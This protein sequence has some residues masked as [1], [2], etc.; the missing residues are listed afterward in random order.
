MLDP[1][2]GITSLSSSEYQIESSNKPYIIS[3]SQSYKLCWSSCMVGLKMWSGPIEPA[4]ELGYVLERNVSS[5]H[6]NMKSH[7][8]RAEGASCR[9]TILPL[10]AY[11]ITMSTIFCCASI[12]PFRPRTLDHEAKFNNFMVWARFP[13][14]AQYDST[15]VV[16][17]APFAVQLVKQVNFG[18]LE[19]K[20]YLIPV[21]G[22]D[23]TFT[24]I[25][26]D[27]LIQAN[28]QKLNS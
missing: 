11:L 26:E 18:P 25:T 5:A 13:K 21:E 15:H 8:K 1:T 2:N 16:A 28:F 4:V 17:D 22:K 6:C 3:W 24:E 7:I 19:S 14:A 12:Q 27:E 9:R 10:S 23:E 20:R